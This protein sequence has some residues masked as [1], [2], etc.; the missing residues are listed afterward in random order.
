MYE[1]PVNA[2]PALNNLV[3]ANLRQKQLEYRTPKCSTFQNL[4]KPCWLLVSRPLFC[5]K[6]ELRLACMEKL[7]DLKRSGACCK[8]E[9]QKH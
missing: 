3:C 9:N 2:C 6:Q 1:K 8:L 4:L 5:I 7:I